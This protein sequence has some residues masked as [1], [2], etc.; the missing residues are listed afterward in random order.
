[1]TSKLAITPFIPQAS[2]L[3]QH[4]IFDLVTQL[5]RQAAKLTGMI[6]TQSADTIRRHMA[7][8]NS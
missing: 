4:G 6:P 3:Q 7:V 2:A 1:M 8:I 5:D